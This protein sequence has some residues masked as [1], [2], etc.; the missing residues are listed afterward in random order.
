MCQKSGITGAEKS[1]AGFPAGYL[2]VIS[3]FELMYYFT[4]T[5]DEKSHLYDLSKFALVIGR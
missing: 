3:Y 1:R 4:S 5:K 2:S